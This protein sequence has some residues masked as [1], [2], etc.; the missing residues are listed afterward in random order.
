MQKLII[1]LA[2]VIGALTAPATA[3]A[4]HEQDVETCIE[5]PVYGGGV[6]VV[7]G[8]KTHEPID[9]DLGDVNF[10]ILG[11][12]LLASSFFILRLSKKA[13]AASVSA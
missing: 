12:S 2:V 1:T 9:T 3:L 7:C 10:A 5:T 11:G 8:A 6:G 13:Q 4:D